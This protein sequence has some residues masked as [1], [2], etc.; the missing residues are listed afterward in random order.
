MACSVVILCAL[1]LVSRPSQAQDTPPQRAIL[2]GIKVVKVVIEDLD[3]EL[4][5]DGV[6]E[7]QLLTDAELLLRQSHITVVDEAAPSDGLVSVTVNAMKNREQTGY[8][9]AL[10]VR[11][12]KSI[13]VERTGKSALG[14]TWSGHERIATVGV[15]KFA[16]SVRGSLRASINEFINALFAVNPK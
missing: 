2:R 1:T 7:D 8:A 14:V 3:P 15:N 10:T 12:L 5:R 6:S 16:D 11:F 4:E 9:Y 13:E